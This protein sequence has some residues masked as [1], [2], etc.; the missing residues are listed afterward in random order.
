MAKAVILIPL[1]AGH[2]FWSRASPCE[3]CGGRAPLGRVSLRKIRF[4]LSLSF[5]KYTIFTV[6]RDTVKLFV[7]RAKSGRSLGYFKR[8]QR[9]FRYWGLFDRNEYSR[10]F[11]FIFQKLTT[12]A[13]LRVSF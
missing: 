10:H 7:T 6:H 9:Y 2:R 5:Q 11:I 3:I 13:F 1:S 12:I 8:K 4:S